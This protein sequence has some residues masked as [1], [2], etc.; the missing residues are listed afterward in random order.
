MTLIPSGHCK[1]SGA[2]RSTH[3]IADALVDSRWATLRVDVM[4]VVDRRGKENLQS[5]V[6]AARDTARDSI[7]VLTL[8]KLATTP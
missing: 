3:L 2:G 7:A 1:G 5:A 8:L 6:T 4:S